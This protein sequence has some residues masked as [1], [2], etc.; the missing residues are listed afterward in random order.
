MRRTSIYRILEREHR[1]LRIRKTDEYVFY[2]RNQAILDTDPMLK[3]YL[4]RKV[5]SF[6]LI[7]AN[8]MIQGLLNKNALE[9]C[10][11]DLV[12]D[13]AILG[14]FND[15]Q[16]TTYKS[17]IVDYPHLNIDMD[18]IYIPFFS[19]ALNVIYSRDPIKLLK[20]PYN[21]LLTN[22]T[23][24][25]VDAF[26]TYNFSLFDSS[27]TKMVRLPYED[28]HCVAFY[29]FDYH[30]LFIINDQGR[31]ENKICLFDRYIKHPN[32]DQI[33]DRLDPVLKAYFNFDR[34]GFVDALYKNKF[35]SDM[36]YRRIK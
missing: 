15:R 12:G 26:E 13:S 32:M 28:E 22:Y 8:I 16:L 2:R 10:V 27:L 21:E 4:L 31:L 11:I 24:T 35:I 6:N 23:S 18:S 25:I 34:N 20:A 19:R 14:P 29:H 30:T 33:I 17:L 9:K 3:K 36:I 5:E 1:N 7:R